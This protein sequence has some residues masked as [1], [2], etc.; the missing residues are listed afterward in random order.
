[1]ATRTTVLRRFSDPL[2][3]Q[4]EGRLEYDWDDATLR[5]TRLRCINPTSQA[6]WLRAEPTVD[7]TVAFENTYA[8]NSGTTENVIPGNVASR[9]QVTVTTSGKLSGVV[10]STAY[11]A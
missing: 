1:M 4:V 9:Y 6:V 7:P 2:D 10:Y 11:P 5:I 8:A 3:S